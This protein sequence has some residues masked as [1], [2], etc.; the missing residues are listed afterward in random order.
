M[1]KDSQHKP[2]QTKHTTQQTNKAKYIRIKKIKRGRRKQ[3]NFDTYKSTFK[4]K[5]KKRAGVEQG[6]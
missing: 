1:N 5:P 2:R 4:S 6:K 3:V